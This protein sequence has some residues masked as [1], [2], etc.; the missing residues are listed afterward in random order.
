[1]AMKVCKLVRLTQ[2]DDKGEFIEKKEG[3]ITVRNRAIVSEESVKES[4]ET[5]KMSGL[6][7]KVDENATAKRDKEIESGV[8]TTPAD[9]ADLVGNGAPATL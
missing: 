4:E 2:K 1:M 8:P 7:Y 6:L 3:S 5:Y 9:D